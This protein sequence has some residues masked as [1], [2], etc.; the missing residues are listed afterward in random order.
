MPAKILSSTLT[1]PEQF[2]PS[3]ALTAFR[4]VTINKPVCHLE[5]AVSQSE[6]TTVRLSFI[7]SFTIKIL[8]KFLYFYLEIQK[9]VL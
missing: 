5:V 1:L 7:Q 4:R 8:N 9:F 2:V 6:G 3:F